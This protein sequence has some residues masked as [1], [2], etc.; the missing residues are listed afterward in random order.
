MRR[1]SWPHREIV[2]AL[3]RD[4]TGVMSS[5][6]T[7]FLRD[8]YDHITQIIDIVESYRDIS[9]G[10]M[11]V[12]LSS[13]GFRTNEIM[14]VLTIVSTFFIPLT[15]VAGVYGMNFNTDSPFNMPELHWKYGYV[16]FWALCAA[17]AGVTFFIVKRKRWL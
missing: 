5:E 14:R 11:D 3:M 8:C 15:F 13:L 17:V 9:A 2:N 1:A 7:V 16:Y 6:T 10:L 4:E 12:Y